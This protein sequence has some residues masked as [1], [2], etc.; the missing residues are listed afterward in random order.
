MAKKNKFEELN[1]KIVDLVGGKSNITYFIHCIT[2]LRFNLKDN[3]CVDLEEIKKIPNVIGVQ[4]SSDQLQVIIGPDVKIAYDLICKQHGLSAEDSIEE[5]LDKDLTKKGKFSITKVFETISGCIVPLIPMFIGIGM[6]QA[7]LMLLSHFGFVSAKTPTYVIMS[8]ISDAALYFLPVAVGATASKKFG[9]SLSI[10]IL[11]GALLIHPTLSEMIL[12]GTTLFGIDVPSTYYCYTI[13]PMI[14][15]VFVC[16]YVEKYLNKYIPL[17]LQQILVPLLTIV[18]MVPLMLIV[19]APIGVTL[20]TWLTNFFV[21]I[22]NKMGPLAVALVCATYPIQVMTGMHIAWDTYVINAY[23]TIGYDGLSAPTDPIHNTCESAACL[24]VALKTKDKTIKATALAAASSALISGISEPAIYGVT[25]RYRKP[26]IAVI[27]GCFCGGLYAG[28][29][30]VIKGTY[31]GS[32]I[33]GLGV[34]LHPDPASFVHII[35]A[36]IIAAIVTFV[37]TYIIFKPTD[38]LEHE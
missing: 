3:S 11:L 22:Y 1:L 28:L 13:F 21:W 25:F 9:A 18:I 29:N 32:N 38:V 19:I 7:I 27:I 34:F 31:G 5:N 15:T 33:L 30:H 23:S 6:L 36:I 2:R 24:A 35:I 10:G 26:L 14:M 16:S 37:V 8:T 20:G 4:W 12:K 17:V